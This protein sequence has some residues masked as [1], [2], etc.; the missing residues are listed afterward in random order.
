MCYSLSVRRTRNHGHNASDENLPSSQLIREILEAV[1]SLSHINGTISAC[2]SRALLSAFPHSERS[3]WRPR[4][5]W[6]GCRQIKIA[7]LRR[8]RRSDGVSP[9]DQ[10]RARAHAGMRSSW[11]RSSAV[12]HESLLRRT[13]CY[14]RFWP[15]S[16]RRTSRRSLTAWRIYTSVCSAMS[17]ASSTS[18]P[19]Y[20]TVLS[21]FVW[22]SSS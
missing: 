11:A 16:D 13:R 14:D 3:R 5:F 20:L 8:V 4:R 15:V 6:R 9:M 12:C 7:R 18:M 10:L 2:L 22:P 17:S 19:R 21:S 1:C